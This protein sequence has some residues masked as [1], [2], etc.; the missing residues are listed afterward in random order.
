MPVPVHFRLPLPGGANGNTIKSFLYG[1]QSD[2][3]SSSPILGDL[4]PTTFHFRNKPSI[5]DFV[6]SILKTPSIGG[7]PGLTP[8][9]HTSLLHQYVENVRAGRFVRLSWRLSGQNE[10][11]TGGHKG[12]FALRPRKCRG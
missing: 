1:P 8:A 7:H 3:P 4:L 10:R 12:S 11:Q 9:M 5:A 6:P 2:V